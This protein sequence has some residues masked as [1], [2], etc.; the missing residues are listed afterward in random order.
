MEL[1]VPWKELGK[2]QEEAL[3]VRASEAVGR[4]SK[5]VGRVSE[6]ARRTF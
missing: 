1:E 6:A 3:I 2:P 5:G 4:A